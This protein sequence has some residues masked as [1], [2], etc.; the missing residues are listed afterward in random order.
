MAKSK[1]SYSRSTKKSYK[2]QKNPML[3]HDKSKPEK[4]FFDIALS[5]AVPTTGL[6][7]LLNPI[8]QALTSSGRIGNRIDLKSVAYRIKLRSN[9]TDPEDTSVR[10]MLVYDKEAD[11]AV[12]PAAGASN[13]TAILDNSTGISGTNCH[14]NINQKDR[15]VILSDK[16]VH[17]Q[18]NSTR[19][20]TGAL[21]QLDFAVEKWKGLNT[22]TQYND[23]GSGIATINTG[24]LYFV[25]ISDLPSGF[26]NEPSIIGCARTRYTDQ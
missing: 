19:G 20:L 16:L 21:N 14:L 2:R 22:Y 26:N 11:A 23:G 12:P 8:G 9:E 10:L 24:A 13:S 4:K 5:G 15:Y 6:V 25:A 3:P 17:M 7:L 1:K 18:H